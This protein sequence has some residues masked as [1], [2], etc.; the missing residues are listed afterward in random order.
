MTHG[1]Q[2]ASAESCVLPGLR[3][4]PPSLPEGLHFIFCLHHAR[5]DSSRIMRER[6]LEGHKENDVDV[7]DAVEGDQV[8]SCEEMQG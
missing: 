1:A 3:L 5:G 6:E 8:A 7:L 4:L 2:L